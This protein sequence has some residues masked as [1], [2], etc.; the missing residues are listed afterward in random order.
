MII[1]QIYVADFAGLRIDTKRQT[2]VAG[3]IKAPSAFAIAGEQVRLPRVKR[4]QFLW[5]SHVVEEG[6]H[7]AQLVH[8]IGR[9]ASGAVFRVEVFET[10]MNKVAYFHLGKCSL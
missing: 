10:L 4:P 1:F 8:G 3:D 5:V 2:P 7:F 6:E 9:Y